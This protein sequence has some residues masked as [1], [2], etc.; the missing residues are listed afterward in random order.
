MIARYTAQKVRPQRRRKDRGL[1]KQQQDCYNRI[2]MNTKP[3]WHP[4]FDAA[5]AKAT[6][7][8]PGVREIKTPGWALCPEVSEEP[9]KAPPG[10]MVLCK[11]DE[12]KLFLRYN[13]ARFRLS[14]L[15]EKQRERPIKSRA[16]AMLEWHGR[17]QKLL[18]DLVATNMSLVVT[19]AKRTRISNVD[20][21]ELI[22]EGSMALLRAIDRFDVFRGFKF[23]T[24]A[25]RAILKGFNRMAS[26]A[27][28]YHSRF[29]VPYDPDMQRSDYD[30][31]GHEIQQAAA[32]DDLREVLA[33]NRSNLTVVERTIVIER[34]GLFGRDKRKTLAEVGKIVGLTNERVRQ[35]QKEAL[36]KIREVLNE[37]Y[38]AA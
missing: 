4:S 23:S 28:Q 15:V 9:S 35:I 14:K 27:G 19:M 22:S 10:R 13:Y 7:F 33:K 31:H 37:Q 30:A 5:D 16:V 8:G 29:G 26:K 34:F 1:T 17:S 6:F 20:F 21:P 12:A 32:V 2:P 11:S 38:L 36:A 3:V 24:Y 18:G 25:C